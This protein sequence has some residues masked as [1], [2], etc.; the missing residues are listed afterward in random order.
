MNY[1]KLVSYLTPKENRIKNMF[2]S[3]VSGGVIGGLSYILTSIF[4]V[5]IMIMIMIITASLLTGVGVFDDLVN[6][7]KMGLIIPITGFAHSV[8]SSAL[9]YKHDGLITGVGANI[10]RLAGSV[11]LYG[12]ISSSILIVIRGLIWLV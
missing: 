4:N 3:F 7:Y 1:N 6:K 11:I 2:I 8:T 9:E 12:V 10:F 5:E